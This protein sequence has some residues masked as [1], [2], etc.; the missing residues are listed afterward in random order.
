MDLNLHG[1]GRAC[2]N[3]KLRAAAVAVALLGA[4]SSAAAFYDDRVQV[5]VGENVTRDSNVFRLGD[6]DA[7]VP[8][9]GD[10]YHS[11]TV[12]FN[13]DAPVSR[14]RFQFGADW[15]QVRYNRFSALDHVEHNGR[16]N[17][18]WQAGDQWNGNLG[19][20][21]TKALASFLNFTGSTAADPLTTQIVSG[22]AN[23][24]LTPRWQLQAIASEMHQRNDLDIRKTQDIDL[25]T[26]QFGVNYVS[27]ANN[28]VGALV[29]ED[30]G[31]YPN[32]QFANGAAF[33][34]N[35]AQHG[36]GASTDWTITGKSHV[37]AQAL[38]IRRDYDQFSSRDYSGF[39]FRAAYDWL[40]T[41]KTSLSVVAQRDISPTEDLQTSFVLVKGIAATPSYAISD[42]LRLSA[43][44]SS[45]IRDYLGD[46]GIVAP[47]N[48]FAGRVDHL[49]SGVV[50]LS[51]LPMRSLT[52]LLSALRERRTSNM[53]GLD[54][55][56][57][58]VNISGRLTF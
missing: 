7:T 32:P 51:Y 8:D 21:E 5:F 34:N 55:T 11:T 26:V 28:R 6:S 4:A 13:V 39:T 36:I 52:V 2:P 50:S 33:T 40:A 56:A 29:R 53:P 19:Y 37:A 18:L 1:T 47:P 44:L 23:Y 25:G 35:Y 3:T 46:P 48:L 57:N 45:N 42:K 9:K 30:N 20:T 12:G 24:M 58:V 43:T 54:Y 17:W 38:Y 49:H 41:A 31:H 10:T 16:L 27:P 15:S 22:S 14:Q